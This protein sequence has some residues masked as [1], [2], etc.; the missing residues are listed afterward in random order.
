LFWNIS[1]SLFI[2][3]IIY[4]EFSIKGHV[5]YITGFQNEILVHN[6]Y[7]KY[8]RDARHSI[9]G[10]T[11]LQ[12]N[13]CITLLIT[14]RP[15][16]VHSYPKLVKSQSRCVHAARVSDFN[17]VRVRV[18][19]TTR[20]TTVHVVTQFPGKGVHIH[21]TKTP[22]ISPHAAFQLGAMMTRA[23][24]WNSDR[25]LLPDHICTSTQLKG[26]N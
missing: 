4:I 21:T 24:G 8:Q 2:Y 26:R 15:P 23:W 16:I 10:T 7:L 14:S 12:D 17:D 13:T 25:V 11:P 18:R 19:Y 20:S 5:N 6:F 3:K 9:R 1:K 22:C